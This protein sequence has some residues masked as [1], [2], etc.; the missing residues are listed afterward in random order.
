[1]VADPDGDGVVRGLDNCPAVA[2]VSQAD[3]DGDGFGDACDP[4][5]AP[6]IKVR[7]IHPED[8]AQIGVGPTVMLDAEATVESP[9]E[10]ISS[11]VI[12][13]TQEFGP[14][15]TLACRSEEPPFRCYFRA[16]RPGRY[17]ITATATDE[18]VSVT[19]SPIRLT[20]VP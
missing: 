12:S 15:P 2:N 11:L 20:A 10:R 9:S 4:G 14:S 13:Y 3:G 17:T 6:W 1:M 18:N 7:L 16:Q 8:G 5:E 19:S